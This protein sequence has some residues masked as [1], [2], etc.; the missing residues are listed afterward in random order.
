M[1]ANGK[2]I[3]VTGG[4]NGIGRELVL[5]LLVRGARVA[6][7]DISEGG[8]AQTAEL[9]GAKRDKLSTH[10]VDITDRAAV[11]A[12]PEAI[13][14]AHGQ[15]DGI[16]NCA[17]IIQ[18]FVR[19]N[20]LGYDAIERITKVNYWGPIYMVKTFLPLLLKRPEA[21]IV[22]V[23]S[24]GGFVPVPGQTMYGATK[25]AVKLFTEGLHS[26]L[27]DTKV[28]V[29]IV[30]PGAIHTDISK[31]SGVGGPPNAE[32]EAKASKI[33]MT[34]P[35]AA[36]RMILDGMEKNAYRV[37]VGSDAKMLDRLS[38]LSPLKAATII[39]QQ[40]RSLLP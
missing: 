36:A 4:G 29:T 38:R 39:Y 3:A 11:E 21:H 28:E 27:V 22:N 10:V 25:A 40:M 2:T 24:M 31:N 20:D 37:M 33:K 9:A 1:Q 13:L 16:I 5:Q 15:I 18:P 14:A 7:L 35:D 6:A 26:E 23:S 30:F 8:L 17:G 19:F 12:L 34:E 32:Q